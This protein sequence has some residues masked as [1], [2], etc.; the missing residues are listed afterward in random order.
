M[1]SGAKAIRYILF[2]LLSC[3][4]GCSSK[5]P[6]P[7]NIQ[8]AYHDFQGKLQDEKSLKV[9]RL[10]WID[11]HDIELPPT[12]GPLEPQRENLYTF[13]VWAQTESP[14]DSKPLSELLSDGSLSVEV[15]GADAKIQ[16]AVYTSTGTNTIQSKNKL[17]VTVSSTDL[18]QSFQILAWF[19]KKYTAF[20]DAQLTTISNLVVQL[21]SAR[22][23]PTSTGLDQILLQ[24]LLDT[25]SGEDPKV[26][27]L[28]QA[29][30]EQVNL[31]NPYGDVQ[32]I[33][34]YNGDLRAQIITA[35]QSEVEQ[36][37]GKAFAKYFHVGRIFIRNIHTDKQL[38]VYTTSIKAGTLLYRSPDPHMA[39]LLTNVEMRERGKQL[40]KLFPFLFATHSK[41]DVLSPAELDLLSSKALNVP[42]S[43]PPETIVSQAGLS[44][45]GES[46]KKRQKEAVNFVRSLQGTLQAAIE[47]PALS[48]AI[49][50]SP[51]VTS[52]LQKE[53]TTPLDLMKLTNSP[54]SQERTVG[55]NFMAAA[56]LTSASTKESYLDLYSDRIRTTPM[57]SLRPIPVN[58]NDKPLAYSKDSRNEAELLSHGYIWH[59]YYRPMTFASVL[60][61]LLVVTDNTLQSQVVK[62]LESAGIIAGGLVGLG[63]VIKEMSSQGYLAGV[64][65]STAV[66]IPT[67]KALLLEDINRYVRNMGELA[68]DTTVVVPPNSYLDRYVFFPKGPI[69]YGVDEFNVTE[70]SFIVQIDNSD[71]AVA[72]TLIDKSQT[73]QTGQLTADQ[74]V[75]RALDS[76][77]AAADIEDNKLIAITDSLRKFRLTT[78]PNQ[79]QQ[80]L[81]NGNTNGAQ[82]LI[83]SYVSLFGDDKSGVIDKLKA[84]YGLDEAASFSLGRIPD[85]TMYENSSSPTFNLEILNSAQLTLN[86]TLSVTSSNTS[87]LPTTNVLVAGSNA[88]W[89]IHLEPAKN[90]YGTAQV[91]LSL[92]S[93]SRVSSTSFV[94]TV[95]P[96]P[97]L[98]FSQEQLTIRINLPTEAKMSVHGLDGVKTR[99]WNA[100]PTNVV[101]QVTFTGDGT[102]QS[103]TIT[104]TNIGTSTL[105]VRLESPSTNISASIKIDA[106]TP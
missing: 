49:N 41:G 88:S 50:E 43:T 8:R 75:Q 84:N 60:N 14:P 101:G 4:C 97:T 77:K 9:G 44:F 40:L 52:A 46:G 31:E 105:T 35:S 3:L 78:L 7:V 1:P 102:N 55:T 15:I 21:A 83:A 28:K 29:L 103:A 38:V 18:K 74:L 23:L 39:K 65:V 104:A 22:N 96:V 81:R 53:A 16:P 89:K 72:A 62:Y 11:A 79:V 27:S 42:L 85:F 54:N 66:I 48:K 6:K 94:V 34:V 67:M 37:F 63:P 68:F 25:A 70:P 51:T 13:D 17:Q 2:G 12:A 5:D 33:R 26:T 73:I 87:V 32:Q 98:K 76:G 58:A 71:V 61:S 93:G 99:S 90:S 92:T 91:T 45:S 36:S 95:L 86:P 57:D 10:V 20:R 24:T 106:N 59:D 82:R 19:P 56:L 69:F 47:A 80:M 100:D 30:Q 64:A